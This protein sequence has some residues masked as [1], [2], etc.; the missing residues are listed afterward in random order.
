MK[1]QV[2]NL[3]ENCDEFVIVTMKKNNDAEI[4]IGVIMGCDPNGPMLDVLDSVVEDARDAAK[5]HAKYTETDS[6][7]TESYGDQ[8]TGLFPV[9]S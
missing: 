5:R 3:L 2:E 8:E 1:Q 9:G 7:Q 6:D 4:D